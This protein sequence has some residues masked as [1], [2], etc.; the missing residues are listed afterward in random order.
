MRFHFKDVRYLPGRLHGI[1]YASEDMTGAT[2]VRLGDLVVSH[3]AHVLF[4][5]VNDIDSANGNKDDS[6]LL[7]GSLAL[8]EACRKIQR[9]I[10]HAT[11]VRCYHTAA[12][13]K[14]FRS[15]EVAPKWL[16]APA[17][18]EDAI[19]TIASPAK[20][21]ELGELRGHDNPLTRSL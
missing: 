12:L 21:V 2:E 3:W 6:S 10:E 5:I 11:H 1:E 14:Q 13:Y 17:L 16:T 15:L 4:N 9:Q 7:Y 18:P 8:Y 19:A 20:M